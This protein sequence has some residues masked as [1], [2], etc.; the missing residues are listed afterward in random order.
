EV[1]EALPAPLFASLAAL[2][3]VGGGAAP[4]VPVVVAATCALLGSLR[5]SLA[6]TLACGIAGFLLGGL[7]A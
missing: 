5:R 2:S 1:L 3:L 7:V 6:L 4:T